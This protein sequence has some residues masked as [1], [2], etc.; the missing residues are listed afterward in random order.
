MEQAWERMVTR[1]MYVTGGL[2]SAPHIEGFGGDY[3]LDPEYAYNETCAS[4]ASLFWN[5]EMSLLTGAARYSDL[6]EWQ[7]YNAANVGMGQT[8]ETYLYNNP[9]AVH[10]GVTRQ[11]W[12]V[13]PCC[14]SNLSRTFADLGKYLYSHDGANIWI[15]QFLTSETEINGVKLKVETGLP[16]HGKMRVHVKP[17]AAKELTLHV[18]K[19]SWTVAFQPNVTGSGYDPRQAEYESITKVWSAEGETLEFDFEPSIQLRS[20]HPKVQG[21]AGKV[22]VT[23]GPLVYCLESIDN[24]GVEIFTAQLDPA[25][26]RDEFIPDLLDG[27]VVVHG[28]TM[29]GKPLTF[30][31]YFL[32]GNRDPSQ[33]AVWVRSQ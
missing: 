14:P 30:I 10:Q 23:R 16:W 19:P 8:G 27:C 7:L 33:M 2:G 28:K 21:H 18:R 5:W 20:A 3:E 32:W 13:V 15:H 4:L 29:D 17:E 22:A 31:P 24:P 9:L 1:R 25:S 11:D 26:L 6:F 12:Y